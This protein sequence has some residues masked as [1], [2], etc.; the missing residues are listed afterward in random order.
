M[1]VFS[2]SS[3]P[4]LRQL[5]V[6]LAMAGAVVLAGCS[7]P[8]E[9]KATHLARG[10]E[11]LEARDFD[12]A[13]VEFKNV[14]KIDPKDADARVALGQVL[15]Q[16]QN[17]RQAAGQYLRVIE[18]HPMNA[19]ARIRMG[20][21]Y[22]FAKQY[23][24]AISSADEV[25]AL[26][27][28]NATALSL[29]GSA[30]A[31][32]GDLKGAQTDADAALV[33]DPNSAEVAA[34]AATL[35]GRNKDYAR[36]E[37]IL[38]TAITANDDS[39][40]LRILLAEFYARDQRPDDA[41][42]TLKAL[43]AR[44]PD[45]FAHRR[46][47]AAYLVGL[48]R[49][50]E[51]EA[52]LRVAAEKAAEKVSGESLPR[53]AL[54]EHLAKHRDWKLAESYLR[55][56][57]TSSEESVVYQRALAKLYEAAR[58]REKLRSLYQEMITEHELEGPGLEARGKLATLLAGERNYDAATLL[59]QEVLTE[60]S[61]D[62]LALTVRAK[63]AMAKNEPLGAISDLRAVLRDSPSDEE[64]FW[65]LGR[66]HL[67]NKEPEL[68]RDQFLRAIE[69]NPK[70]VRVRL[71][72]AQIH[73]REKKLDEAVQVLQEGLTNSPGEL[74]L[75]L[76]LA[77]LQVARRDLAGA[78]VTSGQ[79]IAAHPKRAMGY[80]LA[81]LVAQ[82]KRDFPGAASQFEKAAELAPSNA[83]A[84]GSLVTNLIADKRADEALVSLSAAAQRNPENA[85]V[86]RL[87]G[88]VLRGLKRFDDAKVVFE[89][90]IALKPDVPT[91]HRELA[92]TYLA[93][94]DTAN[95]LVALE[96]G[97]AATD[98]SLLIT[99]DLAQLR[100]ALGEHEV[101]IKLYE[102]YLEKNADSEPATN[103][104]A[105]TLASHR[106]DQG[107]LDRAAQLVER[108][109]DSKVPGYLDTL[110]WVHYKRGESSAAVSVFE[111][112]TA[113]APGVPT[114][115]SHLG[116]ALIATGKAQAGKERLQMALQHKRP[117]AE[118]AQVEV[119]L[120]TLSGG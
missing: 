76:A 117:F 82:A 107:S 61:T 118:R 103:N 9:L 102:T 29:R 6:A 23:D 17:W 24:E 42:A 86:L 94:R 49:T 75:L 38:K 64:S 48:S 2:V 54:A 52:I 83:S 31:G 116:L 68:A 8:E 1:N 47:L 99:S 115:D 98:G 26:Q 69:A 84:L 43:V 57:A 110:G 73:V 65:L 72:L 40:G 27:P 101:A 4:P 111:E 109:R 105:M 37:S 95:A 100:G 67:Q 62:R 51:A 70:A 5:L 45:D 66:A 87:Q 19:P 108:F 33:A 7:D 93:Q 44:H 36:A 60:N 106:T 46:R 32:A 55:D 56:A 34:F 15:E 91:S 85:A 96:T 16:L 63:L 50:D 97:Y 113:M 88:R 79:L 13:R 92:L 18:D 10:H 74:S 89:K 53:L 78:E 58:D 114:F 119:L 104:L 71:E 25:L 20:R 35:A 21:I 90:V 77:R 3:F 11:Y 112:V 12:K 14:L 41:L 22:L 39:P 28:K 80:Y 120:K 59:V 81:G 30:R